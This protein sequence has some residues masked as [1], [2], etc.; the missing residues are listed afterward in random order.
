MDLHFSV[1]HFSPD[2]AEALVFGFKDEVTKID[3]V[4]DHYCM[5]RVE[6]LVNPEVSIKKE[7]PK[8]VAY[9][10]VTQVIHGG[11]YNGDLPSSYFMS[12]V[13]IDGEYYVFQ[14]IG[15]KE[16]MGYLYDDFIQILS[17]IEL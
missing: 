13:E 9:P 3:A 11:P 7:V 10:G 17:S 14:M 8:T 2:E 6:S 15:K 4:H 5:R 1:E 12:T 16:N